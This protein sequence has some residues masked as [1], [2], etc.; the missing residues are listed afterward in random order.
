MATAAAAASPERFSRVVA[1]D[2]GLDPA[3]VH[4]TFVP[5]TNHYTILGPGVGSQAV[6]R[7]LLG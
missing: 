6:T 2:G 1:V 4:V 3:R 7:A 5:G